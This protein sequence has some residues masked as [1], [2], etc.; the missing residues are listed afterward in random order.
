M[1]SPEEISLLGG[2]VDTPDQAERFALVRQALGSVFAITAPRVRFVYAIALAMDEKGEDVGV[3]ILTSKLRRTP[4]HVANVRIKE[5]RDFEEARFFGEDLPKVARRGVLKIEEIEDG[6][7]EYP[8]SLLDY[9]GWPL[10]GEIG[11]RGMCNTEVLLSIATSLGEDYRRRMLAALL[12]GGAQQVEKSQRSIIDVTSEVSERAVA[13]EEYRDPDLT[14]GDM[15]KQLA[16]RDSNAR[17]DPARWGYGPLDQ[18]VPL[19]PGEISVL[20]ARPGCGKTSV[21]LQAAEATALEYGPNSVLMFTLEMDRRDL[22]AISIARAIGGAATM[23][24][25]VDNALEEHQA[26]AIRDVVARD[27]MPARHI[28]ISDRHQCLTH[29]D[30][31]E[32][33]RVFNRTHPGKL[34][35]VVV[36]YLQLLDATKPRD[37]EYSKIS[38]ATRGL[39]RL[40]LREQVPVLMLSQLNRR[41][42]PNRNKH[43]GMVESM[44]E[45]VLSDLR[46][47]GTIEQDADSVVFLHR[48]SPQKNE[49]AVIVAKNRR[50]STG[51][52]EAVFDGRTQTIAA[53]QTTVG[54]S[55]FTRSKQ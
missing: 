41:S 3:D 4:W 52:T 29:R 19:R 28:V 13:I 25:I 46:A 44:P 48:A 33:V 18:T 55:S 2:L 9:V 22:T 24:E 26:A 36:D 7:T 42:T 49:T 1:I 39:K 45:P 40:C 5:L 54:G 35:L 51:F 34:R 53:G 50:G 27:D 11:S 10:L 23:A 12:R 38:A 31:E 17:P 30:I 21:A 16:T 6:G 43:T 20:A 47:S 32:R 14:V 15:C 8:D 37:D